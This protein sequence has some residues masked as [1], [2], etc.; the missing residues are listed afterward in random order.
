MSRP[1]Q[2]LP[3]MPVNESESAG[4][5]LEL[6]QKRIFDKLWGSIEKVMYVMRTELLKKLKEPGRPVEEQEKILE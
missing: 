3:N 5:Q 4:K 1:S 2:L 6:Q